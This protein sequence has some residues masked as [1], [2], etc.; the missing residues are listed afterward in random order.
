[1]IP[2]FLYPGGPGDYMPISLCNIVY[3]IIYKVIANRKTPFLNRLI[4]SYVSSFVKKQ[5][6]SGN[7]LVSHEI[8]YAMRRKNK[9][10]TDFMGLEI[11]MCKAFDRVKWDFFIAILQRMGLCE[12]WCTLI[13]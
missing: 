10:K 7:I 4:S 2:K 8:I 5:L 11:N 13:F 6:I 1:M 9:S 12:T 3:K